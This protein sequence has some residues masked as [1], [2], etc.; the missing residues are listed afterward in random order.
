MKSKY[1]VGIAGAFIMFAG[2]ASATTISVTNSS[3][4][5]PVLGGGGYN[6][7]TCPSGWDCSGSTGGYAGGIYTPVN[8]QYPS[9]SNGLSGGKIVPDGSQVA[10]TTGSNPQELG[11][12]SLATIAANTTYTLD[13]WAGARADVTDAWSAGFTPT[14]DIL[15]NSVVVASL[16]TS[17]PGSGKWKDY[18]VSL[19]NLAL[20]TGQALGIRLV[21]PGT[22]YT[23]DQVNWDAVTLTSAADVGT[24]PI[25]GALWLMG[26]VLAG[27][28]GATRWRRKRKSARL[29][30]AP[31]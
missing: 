16:V 23:V 28:A 29:A 4:E 9:G 30:M 24:T 27:S 19:N 31:A 21:V 5:A 20:Y 13:V 26:S 12:Y 18:S 22:A 2:H 7:A 15:A 1:A 25:P 14:I 17:D 11:Q 6:S 10:W 8:T 3:F